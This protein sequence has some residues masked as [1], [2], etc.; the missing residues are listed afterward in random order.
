MTVADPDTLLQDAE[1]VLLPE[2]VKWIVNETEPVEVIFDNTPL[3]ALPPV[4]VMDVEQ[5]PVYA[6]PSS[7]VIETERLKSK[8]MVGVIVLGVTAIANTTFVIG[9]L[10]E[11][12]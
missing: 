5:L 9:M 10:D 8:F 12:A 1:I 4:S 2:V 7:P 3:I 11:I 6:R